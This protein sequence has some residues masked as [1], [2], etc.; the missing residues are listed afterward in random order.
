MDIQPTVSCASTAPYWI[1]GALWCVPDGFATLLA[2]SGAL[3]AGTL[4][5]LG[6]RDQIG[7]Q[8]K[9]EARRAEQEREELKSA[10]TSELIVFSA[11]L[12]IATSNWNAVAHSQPNAN[13]PAFP[14]FPDPLVYRATVKMLGKL[15]MSW[16]VLSIITFYGNLLDM[17]DMSREHSAGRPTLGQTPSVVAR[18]LGIM[19]SNLAEAISGL[20]EEREYPISPELSWPTLVVPGGQQLQ[21]QPLPHPRTLQGVLFRLAGRRHSSDNVD[22]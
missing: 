13:I 5:W 7:A 15:G 3:V 1:P 8:A 16:P 19:C 22:V 21:T 20:N 10:L 2:G 14:L 4:A 18:K 11:A 17:N 9:S 6:I 12:V